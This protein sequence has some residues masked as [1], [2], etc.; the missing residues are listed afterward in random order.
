MHTNHNAPIYY[1][2]L[3]Q[4]EFER[5]NLAAIQ[6]WKLDNPEKLTE[7]EMQQTMMLRDER[8]SALRQAEYAARQANK[9]M[10]Y[11]F[12]Y[13]NNQFI[14]RP[15]NARN[16]IIESGQSV[17][18]CRIEQ[19]RKY[20]RDRTGKMYWLAIVKTENGTMQE[21]GLYEE[22]A[23]YSIT[24]LQR[25][26][27]SHFVVPLGSNLNK[28]VWRQISIELRKKYV[29]ADI[30][31]LPSKAGWHEMGGEYHLWTGDDDPVLLTDE[32]KGFHVVAF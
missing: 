15:V 24:K 18:K 27:L 30:V 2:P 3:S 9:V 13:I 26:K 6:C 29:D 22:D 5:Q 1:G 11:Q 21:I 20:S 28:V 19:V 31:S 25:T 12:D 32:M 17:M 16:E 7:H 14:M 4:E 10:S 23:M 8:K